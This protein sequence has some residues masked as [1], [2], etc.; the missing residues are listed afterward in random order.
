MAYVSTY[1]NSTY[2]VADSYTATAWDM[3]AGVITWNGQQLTKY[4]AITSASITP[5]VAE[6]LQQNTLTVAAANNTVYQFIIQQYNPVSGKTMTQTFTYTTGAVGTT[7]EVTAAFTA[8][9]NAAAAAGQL[10]VSATDND[11]DVTIDA[12]AGYAQFSITVIQGGANLV[13]AI[14]T[15]GVVAVG[16]PAAL[17]LQGIVV[18]AGNLYT[19]VHM[20]Y[21][22][23]SGQ[24][25]KDPVAV[26]SVFDLYLEEN[27][28]D[29]A[30]VLAVVTADLDGTDAADAIAVI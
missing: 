22:P 4:N 29:Y 3:L 17:A 5:S 14:V 11:P 12:L 25:I 6:T 9:V 21:A 15:P 23:V 28:A 10:F 27:E 8:A 16:T 1:P 7:A 18:P 26:N 20:E 13:D 30:A 2:V 24:N 19:T